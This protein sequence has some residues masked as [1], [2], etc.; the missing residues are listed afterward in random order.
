[1]KPAMTM[2]SICALAL[3]LPMMLAT[4]PAHADTV[5]IALTKLL[6]YPS[7]PIA[8]ERGYFKEQGIDAE[9]IYFDSAEPMSVALASGGVDF[10]VS[11]LG[12]AFYTLAAQGQI[13]LLASAAME[14]GDGFSNLVFIGSNKAFDA[15]LTTAHALPGHSFGVTQVGTSLQYALGLLAEK[16]GWAVSSVP[17]RPLQS[18]PNVITAL[19]G[20]N[21]DAAIMPATP[22]LPLID[23]GKVKIIGWASELIP[24]WMGSVAFTSKKHADQ[25]GDMVK[26]FLTAYRKGS[27]DYHAAFAGPDNKRQDNATTPAMLELLSKF[28]GIAPGLIDRA[29]PYLD[30]DGRVVMPDLAHQI[31][32]YRSQGMMKA[33]VKPEDFVDRRYALL[34]EDGNN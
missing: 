2:R 27:N 9:M 1:M 26:R 21:V 17:I 34:L 4:L 8:I 22:L 25:D 6:S 29:T 11:G 23:G 28:T 10:A 12:A 15:G 16:D 19:V 20:G 3:V 14:H 30:K 32:W 31:A 13:R 5:K 18:I 24:G 33:N 7:V